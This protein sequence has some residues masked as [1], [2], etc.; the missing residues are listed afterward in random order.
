MFIHCNSILH[1]FDFWIPVVLEMGRKV[2]LSVDLKE[3][4]ISLHLKKKSLR[5]IAAL[6]TISVG[7]VR[8]AINV[9][10]CTIESII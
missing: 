9:S 4:I 3:R 10:F 7:A 8:N 6:L 1:A 5:E 2:D